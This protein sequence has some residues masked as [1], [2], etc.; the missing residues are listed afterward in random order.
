MAPLH[1]LPVLRTD[2]A[3]P[4]KATLKVATS[5][6]RIKKSWPEMI[7]DQDF[8]VEAMGIEPTNL[9]HAMQALYQLS[10]APSGRTQRISSR[11]ARPIDTSR[12]G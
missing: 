10:Y 9:L 6:G 7:S 12:P 2:V 1:N 11:P 4:R 5:G 8:L 3:N